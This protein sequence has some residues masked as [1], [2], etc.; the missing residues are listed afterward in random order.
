MQ[1]FAPDQPQNDSDVFVEL[2]VEVKHYGVKCGP[3]TAYPRVYVDRDVARKLI[4]KKKAKTAS[5]AQ[6]AKAEPEADE[7]AE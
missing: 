4:M 6:P 1:T 3:G 7:A 5:T 2:L